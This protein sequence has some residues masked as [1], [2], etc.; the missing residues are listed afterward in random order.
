MARNS[1]QYFAA[2][3][4]STALG[5]GFTSRLVD[6]IRV[7]RSLTY[8]I[9][10]TFDTRL[11]G[12]SFSVSSFTKLE[13]TRALLDA[14]TGVLRGAAATGLTAAELAKVKGYLAGLFAIE[15]QTPEA[16]AANL[17]NVAFY[18]LPQDYLQTYLPRLHAVTLAQANQAARTFFAPERLSLIM[19]GPAA[20]IDAQLKGIGAIDRRQVSAVGK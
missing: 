12:G 16:I 18:H 1:P 4:A 6:E 9:G 10:S 11:R 7:N 20:K 14:T 5:G 3:I 2:E 17:A 8:G 19:V 15:M 13:T